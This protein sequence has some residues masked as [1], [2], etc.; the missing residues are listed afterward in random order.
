MNVQR[1]VTADRGD[2]GRRL[3]LVVR[4]H[5]SDL[6]DATRTRVQ[7]WIEN[8]LVT[9]NGAAV[10]RVAS[11]AALGD[12]VTITLPETAPRTAMEAEAIRLDVLYEDDRL[13]AVDK[14]AGMVVHPT[15]KHATGTVMNAL[16]WHAR[17]WPPPQRPSLVN[18][19]DK[20]TS[21]IVIVAKTREVHAELQRLMTSRQS[22]KRYLALVYGRV[23]VASGHID[24]RLQRAPSDRRKVVAS[25]TSGAPSVTLFDRLARVAAPRAGL[26]LLRCRL[27]TG[28]THQIRVHLAARGWPLVGDPVYGTPRWNQV[29]APALRSALK[30][31]SRQ[32]LHAWQVSFPHPAT[33]RPL[34]LEAPVPEDLRRLLTECRLAPDPGHVLGHFEGPG[35]AD[36]D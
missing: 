23:K 3:D 28:R 24:L 29:T 19:L 14:L 25:T 34:F 27:A 15:Y 32:A 10:S 9:V 7:A 12:V 4:R 20:L 31:F 6:H 5:L 8:G 17:D 11:R 13:M 22:E 1:T 36:F 30:A 18:R 33:G 2:T 21:G 26:T 35:V 16:A